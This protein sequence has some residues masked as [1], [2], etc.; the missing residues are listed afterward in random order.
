MGSSDKP[1][2]LVIHNHAPDGEFMC[3]NSISSEEKL[4]LLPPE[5]GLSMLMAA[6]EGRAPKTIPRVHVPT[7]WE[8]FKDGLIYSLYV[9]WLLTQ[10]IAAFITIIVAAACVGYGVW[11]L[12][13][14]H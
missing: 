7:K 11:Y 1:K 13:Q 10:V 5:G 12:T 14:Q 4:E 6:A 3:I 8:A 2:D 9:G